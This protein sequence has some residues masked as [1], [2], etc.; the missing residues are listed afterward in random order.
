MNI[1]KKRSDEERAAYFWGRQHWRE[2]PTDY[3]ASN[4]VVQAYI[5]RRTTGDPGL[6]WIDWLQQGASVV[7]LIAGIFLLYY[8]RLRFHRRGIFVVGLMFI[9]YSVYRFFLIRRQ[10]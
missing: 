8:N 7:Y 10:A 4:P 6:R 5:N 9:A 2:V 3:W 1:F